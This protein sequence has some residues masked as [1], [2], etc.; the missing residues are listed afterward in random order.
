MGVSLQQLISWQSLAGVMDMNKA[1][2]VRRD[3][4]VAMGGDLQSET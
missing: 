4:P 2:L 3:T 1:A